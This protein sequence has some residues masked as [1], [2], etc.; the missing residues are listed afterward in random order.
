MSLKRFLSGHTSVM[1]PNTT[2]PGL[3]QDDTT[4]IVYIRQPDGT[5]V[6]PTQGGGSQPAWD[7]SGDGP[8]LN[9]VTPEQTGARYQDTTNGAL[10]VAFGATSADWVL[11]GGI[12]PGV[13][14]YGIQEGDG[15]NNI[16]DGNSI[17]IFA[18]SGVSGGNVYLTD[19]AA[20]NQEGGS[21]FNA[22]TWFANAGDGNQAFGLTL[23][24]TGQFGHFWGSDGTYSFANALTGPTWGVGLDGAEY[25]KAISAPADGDVAT[26]Q[27]LQWYDDTTGAPVVR[28]KEKDAAGTL[29][30]GVSVSSSGNQDTVGS[31]GSA[32]ALPAQP[33]HYMK[34]RDVNGALWVVPMY[35]AA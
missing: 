17:V 35:A 23:G 11:L 12:A 7:Q 34:V 29:S 33:S 30:A 32:T 15:N 31:A 18:R 10:W 20:W 14:A 28:F 1:T 21:T 22:A 4:G 24:S 19:T 8:P 5:L 26:G 16:V 25:L 3:Y 6:D 9:T 13:T 2:D 27:R